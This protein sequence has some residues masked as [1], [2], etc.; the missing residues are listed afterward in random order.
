MNRE[1]FENYKPHTWD[2]NG[3]WA[4][5]RAT[6]KICQKTKMIDMMRPELC[7]GFKVMP[8]TAFFP[9]RWY[10]EAFDK[11]PTEVEK[12]VK[13]ITNETFAVHLWS[14]NSNKV[15]ILKSEGPNMYTIF[16]EKVCPRAYGASGSYFN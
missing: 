12:G 3:P 2:Y 8:Y 1:C 4:V 5:W 9:L 14:S 7:W 16:A 6:Q 15:S 10:T 13:K 11:K